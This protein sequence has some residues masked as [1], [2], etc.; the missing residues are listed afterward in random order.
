MRS[1]ATVPLDCVWD[2][3]FVQALRMVLDSE[4]LGCALAFVGDLWLTLGRVR[5]AAGGG[6]VGVDFVW[7]KSKSVP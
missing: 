2:M 5:F 7:Q 1:F 4:R 3:L 6:I